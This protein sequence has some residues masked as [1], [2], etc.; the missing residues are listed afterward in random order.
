MLKKILGG[1]IIT[2]IVTIAAMNTNVNVKH[3]GL[4]EVSLAI[5][6]NLAHGEADKEGPRKTNRT[7][8]VI[9]GVLTHS[10]SS[11][12]SN[13]SSWGFGGQLEAGKPLIGSIT[14]DGSFNKTSNGTQGSYGYGQLQVNQDFWGDQIDCPRQETTS[15]SPYNPC[16]E[17]LKQYRDAF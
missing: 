1:I 9:S 13:G 17:A 10:Q 7:H 3:N 8:C 15:C 14:L 4:S 2:A 16:V 12:S 6:E 5:I 11:G